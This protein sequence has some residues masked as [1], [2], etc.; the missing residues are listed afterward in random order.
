MPSAEGT[1]RPAALITG[2]SLGIGRA[3]A[4]EL[5]RR[6]FDLLLTSREQ[7]A[8]DSVAAEAK[9]ASSGAQIRVASQAA[10]LTVPADRQRL[11]ER[12]AALGDRLSVLVHCAGAQVD[13]EAE[14]V[15]AG[16][17]EERVQE[18]FDATLVSAAE[19]LAA[20]SEQLASAGGARVF[21]LSSDW[22]LPGATG[23]PV[24][25]AAKAGL[26]HLARTSRRHYAEQGVLITVLVL[27]DVATYDEDWAEPIWSLDDPVEQVKERHGEGRIPLRDVIDAIGFVL[28]RHLAQ[29]DE[30]YMMPLR[31]EA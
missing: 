7:K 8:L 15:R 14:A 20:L 16:A 26:L 22:A 3:S 9:S 23:P 12:A 6:G 31:P 1:P 27:G 30:L 11:Y 29:V 25:S 4:L 18:T 13:P 5:A 28:D 2:A 19:V 17:T 24:F 10:D 21:L